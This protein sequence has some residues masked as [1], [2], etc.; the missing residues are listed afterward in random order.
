MSFSC[1]APTAH[2]SSKP[3]IE[4][5]PQQQQAKLLQWQPQILNLLDCK[6]ALD[7]VF[8]IQDPIWGTTFRHL[9]PFSL[10][11]TVAASHTFFSFMTLTQLS[12]LSLNFTP[13]KIYWL[14]LVG[15]RWCRIFSMYNCII[16]GGWGIELYF[17]FSHLSL[18]I[19]LILSRWL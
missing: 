10:L 2:Q 4:P 7:A 15:L 6:R 5:A 1:S 18:F 3:G 9:H 13:L 19:F 11:Q 8:L 12:N 17:F 14:A 16:C